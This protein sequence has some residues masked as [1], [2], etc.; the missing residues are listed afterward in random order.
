VFAVADGMGGHQAGEIASATA[1]E[2]V[3]DLDGRVFP[4]PASA[5]QALREAVRTANDRVSGLAEAR[6]EYRGMGT[7]LTAAMLE[8]RRL[9]V[10][11]VGDSRAYLMRAGRFSQ[12]TDDHTLVQGL[13]DEGALTP[14]E[15]ESHPHR[16]VITRAIGVSPEVEVDSMTLDLVPGDQV[17]LC[18]DGL[19]G[20]VSDATIA[21]VL[22]QRDADEGTVERLIALANE[23]G[24]PDNITVVLLRYGQDDPAITA[25]PTIVIDTRD[26]RDA[27]STSAWARDYGRLGANQTQGVWRDGIAAGSPDARRRLMARTIAIV[28][29]AALIVAIAVGGGRFLLSRSYYVGV[30]ADELVIFQGINGSVGPIELSSVRERTGVAITDIPAYL[31]PAYE[32]GRPAVD[33]E[34]ARRMVAS[35]PRTARTE[36]PDATDEPGL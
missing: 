7:T 2:P 35:T 11:H 10:A 33:I 26:T 20:V 12:L 34:D 15:A 30:D 23:G 4:D 29:S 8:G 36:V 18:S 5:A 28:L 6:P 25:S 13:I 19:T 22:A 31:R 16:S 3:A 21:G 1:L 14:A 27:D 32:Q 17:L 24:G 9:H